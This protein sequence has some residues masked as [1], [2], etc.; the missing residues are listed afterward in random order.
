MIKQ[1][2]TRAPNRIY[3]EG[4]VMDREEFMF[5][6]FMTGA[7]HIHKRLSDK[8]VA[9]NVHNK[10]I[11]NRT[12]QNYGHK[13]QGRGFAWFNVKMGPDTGV[14]WNDWESECKK[15]KM[16]YKIMSPT[17]WGDKNYKIKLEW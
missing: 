8:R 15:L 5:R 4:F 3:P 12:Y 1:R 16:R 9:F 13:Y 14:Y 17:T 2:K 11:F 7:K 6:C 10:Y